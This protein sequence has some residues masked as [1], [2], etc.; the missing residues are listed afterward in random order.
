MRQMNSIDTLIAQMET[1]RAII[2]TAEAI[3]GGAIGIA[4]HAV[5]VLKIATASK[6][7]VKNIIAAV[8]RAVELN[9][10]LDLL[11]SSKNAHNVYGEAWVNRVQNSRVQMSQAMIN[12]LL[13]AAEIIGASAAMSG[14][15][16]AAGEAIEKG[17]AAGKIASDK[18]Y[19]FADK[20]KLAN[21]W[22]KLL[23]V[24]EK[25]GDRIL[26]RE[27]LWDNP[28]LSKYAIAYGATVA[29]DAIARQGLRKAGLT[30]ENLADADPALVVK[31]METKFSED[32][33][34]LK[35][36]RDVDWKPAKTEL[37]MAS[38]STN[39][40]EAQKTKSNP[41]HGAGAGVV[42]KAFADFEPTRR[43]YQGESEKTDSTLEEYIKQLKAL[44][45]A[46]ETYKP[47]TVPEKDKPPLPHKDMESYLSNLS[48]LCDKAIESAQG[49]L[50]NSKIFAK[51]KAQS[52]PTG[53][54][55]QTPT[56]PEAADPEA[57]A[58]RDKAKAELD[59]VVERCLLTSK[60]LGME[61]E[62]AATRNDLLK[63]FAIV[64]K[65]F[66]PESK[67]QLKDA[68]SIGPA[69]VEFETAIADYNI[70]VNAP[71][72]NPK[73][74]K[75]KDKKAKDKKSKDKKSKDKGSKEK[76][77]KPLSPEEQL[78][79][80]RKDLKFLLMNLNRS[81]QAVK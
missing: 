65:K 62:K 57:K 20:V 11:D 46:F 6:D 49:E 1:D 41:L 51:I 56:D 33:T 48:D 73:D 64:E 42:D 3:F 59:K 37:T 24:R 78:D 36:T 80:L 55:A 61:A 52:R 39:C 18:L 21:A 71:L 5:P 66:L 25:P 22:N 53:A 79:A 2:K 76:K 23:E 44:K 34:L 77:E 31:Y 27:A 72:K 50:S 38:W 69:L 54:K 10:Y 43:K 26:M 75:A 28:T 47:V 60:N 14:I 67:T 58:K 7:F 9:N 29:G 16:T 40:A 19:A 8:Q 13:S 68:Q 4:S 45:A 35:A 63:V 17:A 32:S 12:S 15:A 81:I 70:K 74:K 30:S